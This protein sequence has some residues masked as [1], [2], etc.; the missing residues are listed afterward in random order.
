M[1]ITTIDAS[2][3]VYDYSQI[4]IWEL[5]DDWYNVIFEDRTVPM[6]RNQVIGSWY[7]WEMYRHYPKI[8]I[9][10]KAAIIEFYTSSTHAALLGFLIW[11]IY[12]AF[13]LTLDID[14]WELSGLACETS[15]WI[16]NITGVELVEWTPC[17]S[18]YDLVEIIKYP[19]I[20]AAKE[21]YYQIA[22]ECNY[23]E[24]VTSEAINDLEKTVLKIM[25]SNPEVLPHNGIKRMA[26]MNLVNKNQLFQLI[27]MRGYAKDI[28]DGVFPYPTEFS[29]GEGMQDLY[30]L[31][32]ESRDGAMAKIMQTEPLQESEYFNRKIQLSTCVITNVIPKKPKHKFTVGGCTGFITVPFLVTDGDIRSIKGKY[33][34]VDGKPE[35]IWDNVEELIGKVIQLRSITGCGL[36]NPQHKCHICVGWITLITPP[37]INFGY[38]VSSESG[39]IVTSKILSTKHLTKSTVSSIIDL[40]EISKKWVSIKPNRPGYIFLNTNKIKHKIKFKISVEY[41]RL[42]NQI[43]HISI[44]ELT[45]EN[46][47]KIP[48][49][50]LGLV[51]EDDNLIN[52]VYD[53]IRLELS[54]VGVSMSLELLSHLKET[55]WVVD[56]NFIEFN[57]SNWNSNLP[58][59]V[60]PSK[61]ENVMNYF[62]EIKSFLEGKEDGKLARIT[63]CRSRA[64]A[65]NEFITIMKRGMGGDSSY[66]LTHLEIVIAGLMIK[67]NDDSSDYSMPIVGDNIR[68]SDVK[69]VIHNRTLGG[70]LALE[71]QS[72][73]LKNLNFLDPNPQVSHVMSEL[74]GGEL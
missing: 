56:K 72:T 10:S 66:N 42:L 22:K 19:P 69:K 58:L 3:L 17:G 15:N 38:K 24:Y 47:S 31:A 36:T 48:I 23:N 64:A 39:S 55:G 1:E 62:N 51:D 71:K 46:I 61:G 6:H 4:N 8:P 65:L 52:G 5:K 33:H 43:Q 29:Y 18:I 12:Y 35:L 57:L 59:F 67:D 14:V 60:T 41:A 25:F 27:G 32:C 11:E 2:V 70:M 74:L 34:M 49:L 54:G 26:I 13:E 50:Q 30:T 9:K 45:P 16:S 53:A 20:V 40:D 7:Y 63:N 44:K 73:F 21:K 68:F 28:N 37:G